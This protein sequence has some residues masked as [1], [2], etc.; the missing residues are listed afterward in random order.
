[1]EEEDS[2]DGW[3]DGEREEMDGEREDSMEME[4]ER[5]EMDSSRYLD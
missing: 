2:M 3:M 4:R 5:E 1:M